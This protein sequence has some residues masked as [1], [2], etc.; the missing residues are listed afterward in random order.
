VEKPFS[1]DIWEGRQLV[2]AARKHDRIVQTGTQSRSSANLAEAFKYV[3]RG[4]IGPIRLV[5][6][7]VYRARGGIGRVNGPTPVPSSIDY[8]LW[9]GPAP[10]EP[11]MRKYLHYDW[12]W[13]WNTGNGEIGNNGPHTID[14]ARWAL[15]QNELPPRAISIG[16]RFGADDNAETANTQIALF[17]YQPAPMICEVRNLRKEGKD[18]GKFRGTNRGIIVNCE[19]GYYIGDAN[20]GTVYDKQGKTIKEIRGAAA[21]ERGAHM[22][23][24]VNA[25]RSRKMSDLTAEAEVGR[26]SAACSHMANISH[27]LGKSHSVSEIRE[28]IAARP[29]LTDALERCDQYLRE[30]GVDLKSSQAVLGAWVNWDAQKQQFVGDF[31]DAANQLQHP[32]YRKPFEVPQLV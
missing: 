14:I 29:E 9:C 12:H 26:V 21:G 5:H 7:I 8:N 32:A 30:N 25:M 15:G 13:F 22:G 27:R 20:G 6:A 16:G 4:E 28:M 18:I 31:A 23:N 19:G 3:N 10:M 2:A 24:W 17:D 1:H 11:V